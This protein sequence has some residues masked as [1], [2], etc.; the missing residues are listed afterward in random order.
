MLDK[1][2]QHTNWFKCTLWGNSG[3]ALSK[4]LVKGKQVA[5]HGELSNKEFTTKEGH[6]KNT[7]EVRV[8]NVDLIGSKNT[9]EPSE[10]VTEPQKTD[11]PF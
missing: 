7:A 10:M 2:K 11:M 6:L 4:Y 1:D 8:H 5:V 3:Q 9:S